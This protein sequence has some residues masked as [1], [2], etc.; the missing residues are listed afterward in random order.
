MSIDF[1]KVLPELYIG[2]VPRTIQDVDRLKSE[3]G[4]TAVLNLQTDEDMIVY[5][6]DWP[7]IEQYYRACQIE[8][9]RLPVRDFDL[10]ALTEKLPECAATLAKM[11]RAGHRVYLHCT[12]GINR[13]PTVAV[14]YLHRYLGYD[15]DRAFK[16][17]REC[18]TCDPY[19]AA[20]QGVKSWGVG[21]VGEE[22]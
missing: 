22:E 11:I 4:I 2:T 9:W 6:L 1:N 15:L 5:R 14:A 7:S 12:A 16:M 21:G 3:C 10:E 17:V 18:R 8:I 13:S 19:L 20:L